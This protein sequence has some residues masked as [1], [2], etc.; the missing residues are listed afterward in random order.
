MTTRG[1]HISSIGAAL[2]MA[3]LMAVPLTAG[4]DNKKDA[5]EK[6]KVGVGLFKDDNF[7]EAL[8]AFLASYELYPHPD[9]LVNIANC[10]AELYEFPDAM[11][12]FEM[13]L[14]KKGDE[15]TA[16]QRKEIEN[17]ME[18][19]GKKVGKL[20]IKPDD[21]EGELIVD[22]ES[23]GALPL[24]KPIYLEAGLHQVVL[25]E[26][27]EIF[28]SKQVNIISGAKTVVDVDLT[29]LEEEDAEVD[30]EGE[31]EETTP[32]PKKKK[33]KK[34]KGALRIEVVGEETGVVT[35][36]GEEVGETP[37]ETQLKE[38]QYEVTVETPD[39]PKWEG[40]VPVQSAQH[41]EVKVDF[42]ATKKTPTVNNP[43]F[44]T[45]LGVMVPTIASG[46]AFS[47]L[48]K[49]TNDD[50]NRLYDELQ[51]G[52]YSGNEA[53]RMTQKQND[54]VDKGD[55]QKKAAVAFLVVGGVGAAAALASIFIF[56]REKPAAKGTFE[57]S[58]VSPYLNPA[59][60]SAGVGLS[61]T[62]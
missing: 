47:V 53:V 5:G 2:I 19:I 62:F 22:G 60:G 27:D 50:A 58:G 35:L 48:A 9:T 30:E 43:M 44:W 57:I 37:F 39:K 25:K 55:E 6:F 59:D 23:I 45:G 8:E 26:E 24:D 18:R 28:Y 10:Y 11:A 31:G 52:I 16:A 14:D 13:Y 41:T 15:L 17:K 61:G 7:E 49:N 40:E 3:W 54:L 38:G 1:K 32:K 20:T 12:Y 33:K 29:E 56:M 36:D 51:L 21:L 46:V 34:K 4:A 42:N